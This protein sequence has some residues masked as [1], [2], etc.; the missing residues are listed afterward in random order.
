MKVVHVISG[1]DIGGAKTH[2]EVLLTKLNQL[3]PM[4]ATLLCV[5]ESALSHECRRRGIPVKIIPQKQ[6]YDISAMLQM[7]DWINRNDF[8]V[9]H[10]HGARANFIAL[11]L[12]LK[13]RKPMVTTIHSDYLTDFQGSKYKQWVYTPLNI[14][15]LRRFKHFITISQ[16]FRQ[17]LIKRGFKDAQIDV[18]YNG[19]DFESTPKILDKAAFL[20]Q[21]GISCGDQTLLIGCAARLHPVKGVDVLLRAAKQLFT[22]DVDA[23]ILI[24]GSGDE[25]ERLMQYVRSN[26]LQNKVHFLGHLTDIHSFYNAI[27]VNVLP[28]HNEGFGLTLI[29]GARFRLSTIA[30]DVGGI[31]EVIKD[32]ETGR[33]FPP[34]NDQALAN[35]LLDEIRNPAASKQRGEAFYKD[36]FQ[37]FS[38]RQMAER[39]VAVYQ[40]LKG[41]KK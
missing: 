37:R 2:I 27:D 16:I 18:I 40:K 23:L 3:D 30:S 10:C 36:A 24:A 22:H 14:F 21:Y 28:S 7:A 41:E 26:R 1:G 25:K 17:M 13:V 4:E 39:H 8:D 12:R 5:I 34:G 32:G 33:L 19:I 6:R 29:E 38:D 15:S 11:F 31:P 20:Q 35:L 9:V